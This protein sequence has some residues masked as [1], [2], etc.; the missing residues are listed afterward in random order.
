[1]MI[2]S[3]KSLLLVAL[4]LVIFALPGCARPPIPDVPAVEEPG[5]EEEGE[6]EEEEEEGE[7]S[8]EGTTKSDKQIAAAGSGFQ[9]TVK[10]EIDG[11]VEKDQNEGWWNLE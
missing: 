7:E 1:M 6:D 3:I 9:H 4:A 2:K 10:M 8:G 5:E 11:V